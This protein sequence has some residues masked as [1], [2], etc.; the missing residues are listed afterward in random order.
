MEGINAIR[1]GE[2]VSLSEQQLVDC[3]SEKDM[4]CGGGL[5]DY[6]FEYIIKNGGIDS[7]DDYSYWCVCGVGG[8][9]VGGGVETLRPE[10]RWVAWAGLVGSGTCQAAA[11]LIPVVCAAAAGAPD[12]SASAARSLTGERAQ[13][14]PWVPALGDGGPMLLDAAC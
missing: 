13:R 14:Q 5:M 3:D 4:G 7:E 6:A 1:T 11:V 10:G 9:G 8:G 12:C 2:L